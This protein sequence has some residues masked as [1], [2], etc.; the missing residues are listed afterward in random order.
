M[1]FFCFFLIIDLKLFIPAVIEQIF[2][3]NAKLA[4]PVEILINESKAESQTHPVT[5]ENISN[6]SIYRKVLQ[7][8]LGF[9]LIKSFSFSF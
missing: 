1:T 6:C 7:T 4:I 5:Q 9:L 3:P 2:N 8:F